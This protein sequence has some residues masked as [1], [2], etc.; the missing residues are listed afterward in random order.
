MKRIAIIGAGIAGLTLARLLA[1]GSQVVVFEKSKGVGGRMATRRS[2][3]CSFDHGAQFF[4]ARSRA[5]RQ[6]LQPS[7]AAGHIAEWS[8]RV[9]TLQE[10]TKPWKRDWF[11]PHYVGVPTMT[12]LCK[13][14]AN[15][16][17]VQLATPVRAIE[18]HA[19]GWHLRL[20]DDHCTDTFDWVISTAPA[21][22]SR[23]LLPADFSGH[24]A[25]AE[26]ELL[27][28]FSLLLQFEGIC[29][30][31]FGAARIQHPVLQWI[32]CEN[33]KPGRP[34]AFCVTL[35]SSN[36]W[37]AQHYAD[38]DGVIAEAM[39]NALKAMLGEA[40]PKVREQQVKRWKLAKAAAQEEPLCLLDARA[41]LA[42]CGDWCREGTVEG[43][44]HA[45]RDL[46]TALQ[47][48]L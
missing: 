14:L 43:A 40:L 8:P 28:C 37:A 20:G 47:R 35:Q 16:I 39:L 41:Q 10:N 29:A 25:L 34:P 4:T 46:A 44:F 30:W 45:A 22:Q 27:P 1:P 21:P 18:R 12:S 33:S 38:E 26:V 3:E 5:F 13:A 32:S 9:L 31:R 6:F 17:D 2:G 23:V 19:S 11:E 42:A 36:E 15:G 7:L 48:L 24:A